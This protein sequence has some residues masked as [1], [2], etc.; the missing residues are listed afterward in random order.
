MNER[1]SFQK[2]IDQLICEICLD[3]DLPCVIAALQVFNYSN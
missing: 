2:R 1:K 3:I